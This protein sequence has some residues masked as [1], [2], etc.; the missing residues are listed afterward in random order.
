[1]VARSLSSSTF[2]GRAQ[3]IEELTCAW[4]RALDGTA[5]VVLVGGDAGVGKS[6]L[7]VELSHVVTAQG[8]RWLVGACPSQGGDTQPFAPLVGVLRG[9]LRSTPDDEL[10][11]LLA[12]ARNDLARLLPELGEAGSD[13][14]VVDTLTASSGRLFESAFGLLER[15]ATERP[16]AIVFEDLHWADSSTL[17]LLAFLARNLT[18]ERILLLGTYRTDELHRRHPLRPT[19]AE[20]QRIGA[21]DRIT[22]EGF[23]ADE[24]H[25]LLTDLL[26][27]EVERDVAERVA[28]RSGGLAFFVEEL[29]AAI[30]DL[31]H[32]PPGLEELLRTR[33]DR[34]SPDVQEVVRAVAAEVGSDPVSHGL[35]AAVTGLEPAALTAA[36]REAV[37]QQ[38]L[39]IVDGSYDFRHALVREVVVADLLPGEQSDLHAAYALAWSDE[40]HQSDPATAARVAAHWLAAHD[41]EH[42]LPALYRA[43][44]AAEHAYAYAAAAQQY[45]RVLDHW[46]HVADPLEQINVDRL[47][48]AMSATH[49]LSLAGDSARAAALATDE[50]ARAGRTDSSTTR[51]EHR[52]RLIAELGRALRGSGKGVESIEVMRAAL[53]E[54]PNDM[55]RARCLLKSELATSM[56]LAMQLED[57]EAAVDDAL[58]EARALG[59]IA[60]TG[61][62]LNAQGILRIKLE[63]D[64]AVE[65]LEE[66]LALA[67]EADD[68]D[69]ICRGF[70]NLSDTLRQLGEFRRSVEVAESGIE[71]SQRAG[72]RKTAGAFMNGNRAEA[73]VSLGRLREVIASAD[74]PSSRHNDAHGVITQTWARLRMGQ[75]DRIDD[76]LRAVTTPLQ[77][78]TDM[79]YRPSVCRNRAELAWLEGDPDAL[80]AAVDD[81]CGI[82]TT[83][84]SNH[85]RAELCALGVRGE[86]DR[87][88]DPLRHLDEEAREA[89]TARAR[90]LAREA[91]Q[92]GHLRAASMPAPLSA[93]LASAELSRI[94]LPTDP[95]AAWVEAAG[96][97][98]KWSDPYHQAYAGWRM[99]E[100]LVDQAAPL[101]APTRDRARIAAQGAY[102]L[103]ASIGAQ[104]LT[105][106]LRSLSTRAR[107]GLFDA[108][109]T[110]SAN[111]PASAGGS[112]SDG[113][114]EGGGGGVEPRPTGD[115]SPAPDPWVEGLGLTPRE[116]E[117]LT[118]LTEGRTNREI[119]TEL[120]ISV[121]TASV[122]VSNILSKLGVRSRTQAAA[123]AHRAGAG[124]DTTRQG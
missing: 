83:L 88:L 111:D 50:L 100:A 22:L 9:V 17:D 54:L 105:A 108:N 73:L 31:D 35:L 104:R 92:L 64:D 4:E 34:L 57:A 95:T 77:E 81:G 79:Q 114:H 70:I 12:P 51:R 106:E 107:L 101:D 93:A 32:V 2:V 99:A 119:A 3:E 89:A 97:A 117:V 44:R 26:G 122:H 61:R 68:V 46:D 85:Y 25:V 124:R 49:S 60:I 21:V 112:M 42:A 28:R 109:G 118:L 94:D 76:Q 82:E 74:D 16:L 36:L 55:T 38:V 63:R 48:V 69:G 91:Q 18:D 7:L 10:A 45:Q 13:L 121:K 14:I 90:E 84:G 62:C 11:P 24:V 58:V 71:F 110:T 40:P 56:V 75:T 1:V 96:L 113:T 123:V 59:D 20:L 5:G 43:G 39:Q 27:R 80:A 116:A 23:D 102:S 120:Y 72:L 41:H 86:A 30:D 52:A 98:E 103:A 87:L 115:A 33:V 53:A 8:A 15:L 29:A 65:P 66:A 6:R 37:S 19:L 67:Q 47:Q 78:L